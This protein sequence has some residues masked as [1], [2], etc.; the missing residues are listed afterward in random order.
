MRNKVRLW[1][2]HFF[3]DCKITSLP[4][5]QLGLQNPEE[6]D[7]KLVEELLDTMEKSGADFTNSFR[8]LSNVVIP[9]PDEVITEKDEVEDEVLSELLRNGMV[10][11]SH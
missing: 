7:E 1:L 10:I 8:A 3:K 9:S 11:S 6:G 2:V 5:P 4:S